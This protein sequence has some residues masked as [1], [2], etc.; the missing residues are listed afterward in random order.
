M[1]REEERVAR[2]RRWGQK[3]SWTE[4][5]KKERR[6]RRERREREERKRRERENRKTVT[7]KEKKTENGTWCTKRGIR[8]IETNRPIK[9][10]IGASPL[11]R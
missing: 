6:K 2:K 3:E 5:G 1:G 11:R 10:G 9:Q 4:R 8:G 7:L